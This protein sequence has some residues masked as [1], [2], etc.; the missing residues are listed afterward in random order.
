M[1]PSRVSCRVSVAASKRVAIVRGPQR[2]ATVCAG[3][4]GSAAAAAGAG[5]LAGRGSGP[6]TL[7]SVPVASGRASAWM[8]AGCACAG[9]ASCAPGGGL[10][11]LQPARAAASRPVNIR[12]EDVCICGLLPGRDRRRVAAA[13]TWSAGF[14]RRPSACLLRAGAGKA[15]PRLNTRPLHGWDV[16]CVWPTVRNQAVSG[17][18]APQPI[19]TALSPARTARERCWPQRTKAQVGVVEHLQALQWPCPRRYAGHQAACASAPRRCRGF[20]SAW[21]F[22]VKPSETEFRQWRSPVGGGP[23]GN[24]WPRWLS[25]R[26]HTISVRIMP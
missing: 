8:P 10:P 14:R 3:S 15:C 18:L 1:R 12:D 13:G 22:S 16:A 26:A 9:L 20:G 2:Q 5:V 21:P 4:V 19:F 17:V 11:A 23:S 25:Q 24:T 7:A 6:V